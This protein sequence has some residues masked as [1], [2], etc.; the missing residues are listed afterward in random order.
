MDKFVAEL[1]KSPL[2]KL[3]ISLRVYQRYPFVDL[4]LNFVGDDPQ[5]HSMRQGVRWASN[6][7]TRR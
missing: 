1:P 2:D 7:A 6:T 5:R 4:R 3:V